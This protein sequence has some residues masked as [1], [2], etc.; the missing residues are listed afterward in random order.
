MTNYQ[1]PT[2]RVDAEEGAS[3]WR[4]VGAVAA[5]WA[6]QVRAR[7][8]EAENRQERGFAPVAW[9]AE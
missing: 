3:S 1:D 7:R 5:L 2:S 6:A 9:A 8:E 4:P